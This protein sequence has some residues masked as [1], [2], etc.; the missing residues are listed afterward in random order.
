MREARGVGERKG[1]GLR[2]RGM[3]EGRRGVRLTRGKDP[4]RQRKAGWGTLSC[5]FICNN[6]LT[7]WATLYN[8]VGV[9]KGHVELRRFLFFPFVESFCFCPCRCFCLSLIAPRLA[10]RIL[11][12]KLGSTNH[13]SGLTVSDHDSLCELPDASGRQGAQSA[14]RC[15]T[16]APGWPTGCLACEPAARNWPVGAASN[17]FVLPVSWRWQP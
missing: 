13:L 5:K 6:K 17:T 3:A 14:Q 10:Y 1:I 7:G 8:R 11:R 12:W 4:P 9:V 16:S 2:A 15:S